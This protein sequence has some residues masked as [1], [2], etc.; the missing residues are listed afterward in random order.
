[1]AARSKIKLPELGE[2]IETATVV[3]WHA[4]AGDTVEAGVPL[5]TVETDK[6]DTEVPSPMGGI[7]VEIIA[8]V[9]AE[10]AT[11]DPV[12]IIEG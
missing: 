10:L 12:C 9:G 8:S 11:G 4:A 3:E 7:L 5:L 2:G 6:I 1:M